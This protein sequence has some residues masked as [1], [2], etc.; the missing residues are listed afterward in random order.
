M[1]A[2]TEE[3]LARVGKV[4]A[5]EHEWRDRLRATAYELL[6]FL[7]EDPER[8]RLM[9][10]DV[11]SAGERAQLIRD[12]GMMALIELVDQGRQELENP[13]SISRAIAEGITGAIYHRI[14]VALAA[15]HFDTLE[16]MV[17]ELMY[18]AVLPYLGTEVALEELA[19]PPPGR[20]R[21][22]RFPKAFDD[23]LWTNSSGY[24]A[25][26]YATPDSRRSHP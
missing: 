11:L 20:S 24:P 5:N 21:H 18:H 14:H 15:G 4:Y 25:R 12:Q 26:R 16:E 1:Q 2:G 19:T 3:L 17:P 6:R 9:T 7:Q 10:V 23:S 13:G 8:A 22:R